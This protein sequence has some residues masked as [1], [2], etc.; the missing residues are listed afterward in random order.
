MEKLNDQD[1]N[2]EQAFLF[3]QN[4]FWASNSKLIGVWKL[5]KFFKFINEQTYETFSGISTDYP[6]KKPPKKNIQKQI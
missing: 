6:K 3:M 2:E 4:I 1:L 5:E